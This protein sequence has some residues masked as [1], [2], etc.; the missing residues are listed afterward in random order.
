ML[1][2]DL[3]AY[4]SQVLGLLVSVSMPGPTEKL[5]G[6]TQLTKTNV[7]NRNKLKKHK[8]SFESG[9]LKILFRNVFSY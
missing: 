7:L 2:G 6:T 4:D 3:P 5:L 1:Y 8:W 9:S